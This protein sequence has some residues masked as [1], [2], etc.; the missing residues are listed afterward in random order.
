MSAQPEDIIWAD[1]EADIDLENWTPL[2]LT[3]PELG[4]R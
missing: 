2:D 1:S 4:V 3:V